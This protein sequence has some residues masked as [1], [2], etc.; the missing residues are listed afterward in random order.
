[1]PDKCV[2]TAGSVAE[3]FTLQIS[4]VCVDR[5]YLSTAEELAFLCGV[6]SY[7]P[8]LRACKSGCIRVV[9]LNLCLGWLV[10]RKN[11]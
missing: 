8:R 1:M 10:N 4:F 3:S 7:L 5:E 2:R 11:V 9:H 6:P